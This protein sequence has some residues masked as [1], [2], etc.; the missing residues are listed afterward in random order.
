MPLYPL[1]LNGERN[2]EMQIEHAP[3]SQE[4]SAKCAIAIPTDRCPVLM[5]ENPM[6]PAASGTPDGAAF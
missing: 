4:T 6:L 1:H 3:L 5:S 2:Y